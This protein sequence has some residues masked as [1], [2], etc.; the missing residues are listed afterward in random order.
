MDSVYDDS[1]LRRRLIEIQA[2]DPALA[3]AAK[4]AGL[5]LDALLAFYRHQL[6]AGLLF[7]PEDLIRYAIT[8]HQSRP[9]VPPAA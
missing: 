1:A 9:I 3:R 5:Q 8:Q 4:A 6:R 7:T 2:D